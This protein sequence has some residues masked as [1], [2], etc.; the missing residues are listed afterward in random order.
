MKYSPIPCKDVFPPQNT[1]KLQCIPD[2]FTVYLAEK[3]GLSCGQK[4]GLDTSIAVNQ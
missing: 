4:S 1:N 2:I 3:Y